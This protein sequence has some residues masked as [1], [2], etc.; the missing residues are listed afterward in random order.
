[1]A[2]ERDFMRSPFFAQAT[3]PPAI[4]FPTPD[5]PGPLCSMHQPQGKT[6]FGEPK[7]VK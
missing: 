1:M 3:S 2:R 7:R 4:C 6:C 5:R